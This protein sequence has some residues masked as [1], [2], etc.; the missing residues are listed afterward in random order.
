MGRDFSS[1]RE[2]KVP[3]ALENPLLCISLFVHPR[4]RMNSSAGHVGDNLC[5]SKHLYHIIRVR[6]INW[7]PARW[8]MEK[9]PEAEMDLG[10]KLEATLRDIW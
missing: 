7:D 2:H 10:E 1:D 8:V 6:K 9:F 4:F 5:A 3:N